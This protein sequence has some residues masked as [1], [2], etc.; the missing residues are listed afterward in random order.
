M[1]TC[2]EVRELIPWYVTGRIAL[3]DA[4]RIAG[5][6]ATC[7]ECQSDFVEAAWLRRLVASQTASTPTPREGTWSRVAERAGIAD[8]ARIDVGSFLIGL[9]FGISA[10]SGRYP[11]RGSLRVMGH[12]VRIVGRRRGKREERHVQER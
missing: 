7:A 5:H 11:V 3:A 8:V 1:I 12:N 4:E 2:A 6:L 9:S 10:A